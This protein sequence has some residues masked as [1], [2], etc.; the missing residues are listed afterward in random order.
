M[1]VRHEYKWTKCGHVEGE[2]QMRMKTGV[3]IM[4]LF[5]PP[6]LAQFCHN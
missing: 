6:K 1:Q 5:F 3:K 2:I 4:A